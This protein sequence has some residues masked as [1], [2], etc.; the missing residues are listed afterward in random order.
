[1]PHLTRLATTTL[2][3]LMLVAATLVVVATTAGR[4]EAQEPPPLLKL[5]LIVPAGDERRIPTDLC[6][7]LPE[8]ASI[9]SATRRPLVPEAGSDRPLW[10][11]IRPYVSTALPLVERVNIQ[12]SLTLTLPELGYETCFTF[13]NGIAPREAQ[14][15]AQAYKYYA[16]V[17]SLEIR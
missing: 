14:G 8:E 13:E 6:V 3:T 11:T 9:V 15:V 10:M 17:V 5:D 7:F 2:V 4:A 12:E 16:Q 1:M